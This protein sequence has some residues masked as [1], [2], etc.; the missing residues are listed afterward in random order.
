MSRRLRL[1]R[2]VGARSELFRRGLPLSC[3]RAGVA[4]HSAA[5]QPPV[6]AGADGASASVA[7]RTD[8][9]SLLSVAPRRPERHVARAPAHGSSA[10]DASSGSAASL[11]ARTS[12]A[13]G[14]TPR[15]SRPQHALESR[16]AALRARDRRV[17]LAAPVIGPRRELGARLPADASARATTSLG[18][19]IARRER[20]GDALRG[21]RRAAFR[22]FAPQPARHARAQHAVATELSASNVGRTPR[23]RQA[24]SRSRR[25]Q[26]DRA[27]AVDGPQDELQRDARGQLIS[28]VHCRMPARAQRARVDVVLEDL[29]RTARTTRGS[30]VGKHNLRA[31]AA[32]RRRDR[33]RHAGR[34]R[35]RRALR[36]RLPRPAAR[37]RV[38][39]PRASRSRRFVVA[40]RVARCARRRRRTRASSRPR[41]CARPRADRRREPAAPAAAPSRGTAPELARARRRRRRGRRRAELQNAP[42]ARGTLR[43][44]ERGS[45]RQPEPAPSTMGTQERAAARA[46]RFSERVASPSAAAP[47]PRAPDIVDAVGVAASAVALAPPPPRSVRPSPARN[48]GA[49][50]GQFGAIPPRATSP[51][52][53]GRSPARS[54][55]LRLGSPRARARARARGQGA[56][57]RLERAPSPAAP[58]G[59]RRP[60]TAS[61]LAIVARLVL[62]SDKPG[63]VGASPEPTG[64]AA[65]ASARRARRQP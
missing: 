48:L 21:G 45:A 9:S 40:P 59:G 25:A 41:R 44:G 64:S 12:P 53:S 26:F 6:R 2:G 51:K 47:T 28:S 39:R 1:R 43:R 18:R 62:I 14:S 17:R 52:L 38:R 15:R 65:R 55:S 32:R 10:C 37:A 7:V 13:R 61:A 20:R 5:P 31:A 56:I 3:R 50:F 49:Q 58:S 54:R 30:S 35:Q 34:R 60:Q 29:R 57:D 8:R 23:R 4:R 19:A 27:R 16:A 22:G 24:R 33:D 42:G 11:E 36:L 46:A 63:R